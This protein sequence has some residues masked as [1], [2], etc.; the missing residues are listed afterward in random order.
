MKNLPHIIKQQPNNIKINHR[1]EIRQNIFMWFESVS[2]TH[3]V[4]PP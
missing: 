3:M 2:L 1:Y 4:R